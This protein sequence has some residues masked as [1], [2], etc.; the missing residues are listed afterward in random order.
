MKP[1]RIGVGLMF[2]VVVL[3][4][5]GSEL[6]PSNPYGF[7]VA[8]TL[9]TLPPTATTSA[10][11]T[12]PLMPTSQPNSPPPSPTSVP[13]PTP[14]ASIARYIGHNVVEG[15]TI[16]V[17]AQRGGSSAD[18]I[19]RYNR[20][21]REPQPGRELII[22]QLDGQNSEYRSEKLMVTHGHTDKPWIA[23]TFD[24]G[25]K[26]VGGPKILDALRTLNITTT[27]FIS[28]DSIIA[29][30]A[31]LRQM[32]ADGHEIAHHSYTH[33]SF[34]TLT[35]EEML[36]ELQR[37]EQ[38]INE[39]VGPDVAVRPYFRFPYGEYNP[40]ALQTVIGAGY[41]PIHWTLDGRDSYGTE[42]SPPE[43]IKRRLTT[44]LADDELPGAIL[45]S[46]CVERT[47][48]IVPNVIAY[49]TAKGYEFD[50]LSE[51]LER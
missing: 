29:N 12:P 13:S 33:R 17:L 48:S 30:P 37:T 45:L 40:L 47:A 5:C 36:D 31:V 14:P 27:F 19:K 35:P 44:F 25:G 49:Y 10:T 11:T 3:T 42:L 2:V 24:C 46:H 22:P 21:T 9:A 18:L 28:G 6:P 1:L 8:Q 41:V 4:R 50:T 39:I 38:V 51:V 43:E 16:A 7:E 26:N 15:E 23:W 34:L 32:V 20:L